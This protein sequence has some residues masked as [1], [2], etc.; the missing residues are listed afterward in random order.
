MAFTEK[1]D[2]L[3]LLINILKEHEEKL[4][5]LVDRLEIVSKTIQRDPILRKTLLEYE[6]AEAVTEKMAGVSSIL[7]VDDDETDRV[8]L[9]SIL[10]QAGHTVVLARDGDEA[11]ST[12]LAERVH[13]VV[14]DMV[15]PGRDGLGLISALRGV[16]P[17]TAIIAISGALNCRRWGTQASVPVA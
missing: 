2:V 5:T 1:I 11:L 10:E 15:M 17:S 13:L 6:G 8:G 7:V 16:D 12:F 3:D 9:S 4:D 14:T